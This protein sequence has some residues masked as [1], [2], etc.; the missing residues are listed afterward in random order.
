MSEEIVEPCFFL[1]STKTCA[2][3]LEMLENFAFPQTVAEV[4]S[5][6]LQQDGASTYFSVI[7]VLLLVYGSAGECRLSDLHGVLT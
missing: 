1:E 4:D 3:Y 6:L 5:L 7:Y 2:V